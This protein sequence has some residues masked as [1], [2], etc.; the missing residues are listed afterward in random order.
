[1]YDAVLEVMCIELG[2][3]LKE[4]QFSINLNLSWVLPSTIPC[5]KIGLCGWIIYWPR[6]LMLVIFEGVYLQLASTPEYV[7]SHIEFGLPDNY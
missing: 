1:M 4:V 3:C 7:D 5:G 2:N 6:L